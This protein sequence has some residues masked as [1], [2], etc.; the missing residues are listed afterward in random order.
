VKL[1]KISGIGARM[2]LA[3]LSGMSVQELA[4]ACGRCRTPRV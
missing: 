3:V 4:L 2:A 1:L